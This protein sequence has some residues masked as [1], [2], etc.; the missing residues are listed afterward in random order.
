MKLSRSHREEERARQKIRGFPPTITKKGTEMQPCLAIM[1]MEN[2]R[3]QCVCLRMSGDPH[4]QTWSYQ[5]CSWAGHTALSWRR[6]GNAAEVET[7]QLDHRLDSFLLLLKQ[8]NTIY[9]RARYFLVIYCY[10]YFLCFYFWWSVTGWMGWLKQSGPICPLCGR[11][12]SAGELHS[13]LW[14]AHEWGCV[15]A[16]LWLGNNSSKGPPH[17]TQTEVITSSSL[18][19]TSKTSGWRPM[20]C[21]PG[22]RLPLL[23]SCGT[24]VWP[25]RSDL[26]RRRAKC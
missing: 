11:W 24:A 4:V 1:Y 13:V 3:G 23:C 20:C 17:I 25:R 10:K 6:R 19:S 7:E 22:V 9:I 2:K 16:A 12:P 21:S 8:F 18:I 14:T 26:D 15:K 5:P